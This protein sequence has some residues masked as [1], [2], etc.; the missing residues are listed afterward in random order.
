MGK[1]FLNILDKNFPVG[2]ILRKVFNRHTVQLSYRTMPNM[3]SIIAANN[4][5]LLKEVPDQLPDQLPCNK[6]CNCRGGAINC[7][8]DGARC[9]DNKV[10]YQATV[11]EE[12][13]P[14]Q[15]Y[16]GV[17]EPP[18]KKRY[19]SHK[20]NMKHSDQRICSS[21]AGYVWKLKDEGREFDVRWKILQQHTTFNPTTNPADFACRK[22]T[23]S[24]SNRRWPP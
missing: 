5:R 14:D 12:G 1:V 3:A 2:H 21:L 22:S 24:C 19:G 20:S 16:V 17:T 4:R 15:F 13:K 6:N 8:M 10:K 7:P 11:V 18:W 23:R 9:L